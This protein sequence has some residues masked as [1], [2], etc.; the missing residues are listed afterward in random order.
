MNLNLFAEF[1]ISLIGSMACYA[2]YN[3]LMNLVLL[4]T[5]NTFLTLFT[6]DI[7]TDEF[8]ITFKNYLHF[9]GLLR[10]FL[11]NFF[12]LFLLFIIL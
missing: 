11:I 9:G 8:E 6:H 10:V 4:T 5:L 12:F 2:C 7:Y 1:Q 3:N